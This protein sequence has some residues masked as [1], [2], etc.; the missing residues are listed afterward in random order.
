MASYFILLDALI[1][2]SKNSKNKKVISNKA[3]SMS[4]HAHI[5]RSWSVGEDGQQKYYQ[6]CKA[7]GLDV[8]KATDKQDMQHIDFVVEGKTVDVKGLKDTHKEGKILLEL[9]NV[10]GKDGWCSKS[11]PQYVA[12]DF[13]AFFFHVK[14]TDLI[15]LIKKKCDLAQKVSKI[16]DA[17]YKSYSRKDRE[18]LMTVVSLTDVVKECEHWYLPNREWKFPMDLI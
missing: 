12:F 3:K 13:G 18:D 15:K 1:Y 9:K 2:F 5:K 8:K 10:Q 11:G 4:S 14:N 6:S 17:L 16:S 7:A